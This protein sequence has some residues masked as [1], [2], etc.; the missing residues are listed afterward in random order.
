M[1]EGRYL[2]DIE[3]LEG[4]EPVRARPALY[5][6]DLSQSAAL[7]TML[8]EPLCLA[9]DERTGGPARTVTI[10]LCSGD[11]VVVENDGPGLP[12]GSPP[13]S[14]MTYV[15]II[16]TRLH[17]CREAKADEANRRWCG[18]G[19]AVVNALSR[20]CTIEIRQ[21]GKI[22]SQRFVEGRGNGPLR[23]EIHPSGSLKSATGLLL[24]YEID[25]SILKG[26][27]DIADIHTRLKE[28]EAEVPCTH[29][30][31]LDLRSEPVWA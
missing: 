3:A 28:F 21:D 20:S 10:S 14:Q 8:L 2:G 16:M 31:F 4:L 25:R 17:A 9:V 30:E 13:G 5:V 19:I 12:L 23:R 26:E 27:Y 7:T 6:G 29:V 24:R 11:I 1:P 22:W 18:A 15:E